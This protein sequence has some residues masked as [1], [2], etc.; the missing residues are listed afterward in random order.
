L[1]QPFSYISVSDAWERIRNAGISSLGSETVSVSD[2]YGRILA[3]DIIS[4]VN[5]PL[6][7]LTHYDG[8]AIR[9]HD[10]Q[11]ANL[12]PV[13]LKVIGK[14][15]P[16]KPSEV[17]IREGEACYI[18]TG[19]A[20]PPGADTVLAVEMASQIKRDLI[21]VR[22][23]IEPGEHLIR[24]GSD[25]RKGEVVMSAGRILR[26]QDIILL[27]LLNFETVKVHR[28]PAVA[29]ISVGDE[30]ADKVNT[31]SILLSRWIELS[32]GI[33]IDCGVAPDDVDRIRD[34]I[35]RAL[36]KADVAITIGGCSMGDKDLVGDAINSA[37]KP[38]LVFQ[39]IK[40]R[41]GRVSA[42]GIIMGKPI[43]MLPGLIHSTIVGFHFLVLPLLQQM[44][45]LPSEGAWNV[46]TAKLAEKIHFRSFIPFKN[47]TFVRLE[48]RSEGLIAHP[49]LGDS[50]FFGIV[51][52]ADGFVVAEENKTS[53]E[54]DETV[55]VH[56]L[57]GV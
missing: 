25:I 33:P 2:A 46:I 18:T 45:G 6:N 8:Y 3:A 42:F 24:A 17:T 44:R 47:V 4:P 10:T 39:G 16:V 56:I 57:P 14:A 9:S 40:I 19:S 31:H 38:G 41:P 43:V 34:R 13:S 29:V 55:C 27:A 48:R 35:T 15:Y 7:D 21:Q 49:M 20:L 12:Q 30:L 1:K 53:I 54:N 28:R 26:P 52:K 11:N 5:V 51:S 37:G 36:D 23:R 22:T 32:G 50:S